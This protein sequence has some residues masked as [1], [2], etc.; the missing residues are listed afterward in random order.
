QSGC[1]AFLHA[2][3]HRVE[4]ADAKPGRSLHFVNAYNPSALSVSPDPLPLEML[5]GVESASI[6]NPGAT[7]TVY[8]RY[9]SLLR[10]FLRKLGNGRI[11]AEAYSGTTLFAET[12]L[13]VWHDRIRDGEVIRRR[14]GEDGSEGMRWEDEGREVAGWMIALAVA[15]KKG[16]V[17]MPVE[18]ISL[19]SLE[20][21]DVGDGNR[22]SKEGEKRRREIHGR[23]DTT[24]SGGEHIKE[25]YLSTMLSPSSN[26]SPHSAHLAFPARDPFI[27]SLMEHLASNRPL[28][29][30]FAV[31]LYKQRCGGSSNKGGNG[32][33]KANSVVE[34]FCDGLEVSINEDDGWTPVKKEEAAV[35]FKPWEK[36]CDILDGMID[37]GGW[38]DLEAQEGHIAGRAYES[39]VSEHVRDVGA[40][41][42]V[43][44]RLWVDGER[45]VTYNPLPIASICS[46]DMSNQHATSLVVPSELGD[47]PGIVTD[48]L[49]QGAHAIALMPSAAWPASSFASDYVRGTVRDDNAWESLSHGLRAGV[50]FVQ[51][52]FAVM[53]W[54]ILTHLM[55]VMIDISG[56]SAFTSTMAKAGKVSSEVIAS[57]IAKYLDGII[58]ILHSFGGDVVK[59][60]GD[61]VLVSFSPIREVVSAGPEVARRAVL[62]C[63]TIMTE[64]PC[65]DVDLSAYVNIGEI[66]EL[67]QNTAQSDDA[68]DTDHEPA[69]FWSLSRKASGKHTNSSR[70]SSV[71]N[72]RN[73]VSGQ[74]SRLSLRLHIAITCGTVDRCIIGSPDTRLDYVVHGDCLESMSHILD[75]TGKDQLG[76]ADAAWVLSGYQSEDNL[77]SSSNAFVIVTSENLS[78]ILSKASILDQPPAFGTDPETSEGDDSRILKFLP[79]ALA[80]RIME[81]RRD[82]SRMVENNEYRLITA[83]FVKMKWDFSEAQAQRCMTCYLDWDSVNVAARLLSFAEHGV[84]CD[85]V[86]HS[87]TTSVGVHSYL[88]EQM[89]KGKTQAVGVWALNENDAA[90]SIAKP[91]SN[92][93]NQFG[94]VEERKVISKAVKGWL[95]GGSPL[96]VIVEGPSGVG[97]TSL[98]NSAIGALEPY[99]VFVS[100]CQGSTVDQGNPYFAIRGLLYRVIAEMADP[101]LP[102]P[103]TRRRSSIYRSG[104]VS[105]ASFRTARSGDAQEDDFTKKLLRVLKAA[106]VGQETA[107]ILKSV[108]PLSI[109]ESAVTKAMSA[110]NRKGILQS[111]VLQIMRHH[112]ETSRYRT[113]IVLDDAQWMDTA[114][115]ELIL[116]ISKECPKIAIMVFMRPISDYAVP[117][118][119]LI[120]ENPS[121]I[122]MQLHGLAKSDAKSLIVSSLQVPNLHAAEPSLLESLFQSLGGDGSP[123]LISTIISSQRN[124][125]L[126]NCEVRDGTLFL[127]EGATIQNLTLDL[128]SGIQTQYDSLDNQFKTFL[129]YAAS[130]GQYFDITLILQVFDLDLQLDDVDAW[131]ASHDAFAFL[132]VADASDTE[133]RSYYFRHISIMNCIYEGI[134][135]TDRRGIH[136]KIAVYLER[137]TMQNGSTVADDEY[138]LPLVTYHFNRSGDFE[139]TVKYC[140][141]LGLVYYRKYMAAEAIQVMEFLIAVVKSRQT[142]IA[143]E[144][145]TEEHVTM[146][147]KYTIVRWKHLLADNY[148]LNGEFGKVLPL[149]RDVLG[150]LGVNWPDTPAECRREVKR[151]LQRQMW[152]WYRSASATK[153]IAKGPP[154]DPEKAALLEKT[155]YTFMVTLTTDHESLLGPALMNQRML[156]SLLLF[157]TAILRAKSQRA[158]PVICCGV[159]GFMLLQ[160]S[161]RK[162]RRYLDRYAYLRSRLPP[163]LL[164]YTLHSDY[165]AGMAEYALGNAAA[166]RAL[167]GA[168]ATASTSN[169]QLLFA[170]A[171]NVLPTEF[172]RSRGAIDID[173]QGILHVDGFAEFEKSRNEFLLAMSACGIARHMWFAGDDIGAAL[174]TVRAESHADRVGNRYHK[175]QTKAHTKTYLAF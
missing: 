112:S 52:G 16:G 17:V 45:R 123:L 88:G 63:A 71:T 67:G 122:H 141:A 167:V 162:A 140:D 60:L 72:S 24:G 32:S 29:K 68:A 108:F 104:S 106:N 175:Q 169:P 4:N 125:I 38:G 151:Q 51:T 101:S 13:L 136:L 154:S 69:A 59:F 79:A 86:T 55:Q 114:S 14:Q 62:C 11:E 137:E 44:K 5:C 100:L 160:A 120:M 28:S 34:T 164:P 110:E 170:I 115:M 149:L 19:K 81:S 35:L 90:R 128:G 87:A 82:S 75:G 163:Q 168:T 113:T 54:A 64:L 18:A 159:V 85:V 155:L 53:D 133:N 46:D 107:S 94:Y 74:S 77:A 97:K 161:A 166:G 27:W 7:I 78:S 173:M 76:I 148:K 2:W 143:N 146:P 26:P 6:L 47:M 33:G 157:N 172:M 70:M 95:S 3:R 153:D 66:S 147:A 98:M 124:N 119:K 152:R 10:P 109:E 92:A 150:T 142:E 135:F 89:L 145:R 156:A 65:V 40:G 129:R 58:R 48:G 105:M 139:K 165:M 126:K 118:I 12:P 134:S 102:M 21:G 49:T 131:V 43:M 8:T 41:I 30:N 91:S 84:V 61:A 93:N 50:P 158:Q 37:R 127:M 117:S 39:D 56:Y 171:G 31:S 73:Y 9:P 36:S 96:L 83:A 103:L 99:G 130:M 57:T 116:L 132:S 15:W 42:A 22:G 80:H 25:R 174:W 20:L 23:K 138:V 111:I 144:M 121:L 1:D